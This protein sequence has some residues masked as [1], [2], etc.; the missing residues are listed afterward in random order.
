MTRRKIDR[1][2]ELRR[3]IEAAST[4]DDFAVLRMDVLRALDDLARLRR[5]IRDAFRGLYEEEQW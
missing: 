5:F 4:A 3:R 1:I 2:G